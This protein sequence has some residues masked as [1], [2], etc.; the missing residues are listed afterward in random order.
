MATAS[1]ERTTRSAHHCCHRTV[2]CNMQ[3]SACPFRYASSTAG[4]YMDIVTLCISLAA[5]P[6][7]IVLLAYAWKG[8]L[9]SA[10]GSSLDLA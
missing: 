5:L 4:V 6:L 10:K 1:Q 2:S 9:P 7:C 3:L 8:N